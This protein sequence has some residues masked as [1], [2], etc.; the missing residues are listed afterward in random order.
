MTQ[1][2]LAEKSELSVDAIRRVER[3]SMSPT[4]ETL[5]KLSVGLELT[6]GTL[7]ENLEDDKPSHVSELCDYLTQRDERDIQL[8]WRVIH[9]MFEDK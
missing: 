2:E 6:L 4:L 3:G 9:A 8:A 5:R 1:E 7:F